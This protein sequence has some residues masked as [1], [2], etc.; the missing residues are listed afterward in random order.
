MTTTALAR[1][2][3]VLVVAALAGGS[4]GCS[5]TRVERPAAARV[6]GREGRAAL[7]PAAATRTNG[8]APVCGKF[9]DIDRETAALLVGA[10][11]VFSPFIITYLVVSAPLRLVKGLGR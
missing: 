10:L 7:A 6:E 8:L 9:F 5:A 11:V 4:V 3:P 1:L 2:A